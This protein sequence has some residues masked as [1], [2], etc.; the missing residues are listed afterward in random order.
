M[1]KGGHFVGGEGSAIGARH[2]GMFEKL[3]KFGSLYT[4]TNK[5]FAKHYATKIPLEAKQKLDFLKL[6]GISPVRQKKYAEIA[7]KPYGPLL[8]FHV[9]KHFLNKYGIKSR[10][11]Q[12]K[13]DPNAQGI[14]Y[15]F[16]EGLPREFLR[17]IHKVT[18]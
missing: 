2:G 5:E 16:P 12:V 3:P 1:T 8:E 7:A 9:P 6:Q 14:T 15:A 10:Q 17:K 11:L 18:D 13:G 4:S